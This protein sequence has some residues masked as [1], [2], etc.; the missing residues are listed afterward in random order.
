MIGIIAAMQEELQEVLALMEN[1]HEDE[2]HGIHFYHGDLNGKKVV[3]MRSGI[4]KIN[5]TFATTLLLVKY[6][7]K[8]VINVGSAGGLRDD[9]RI[10]DVVVSTHVAQ[11]DLDVGRARG[12]LGDQPRFFFADPELVSKASQLKIEGAT[13]HQGLVVSGDQ[14]VVSAAAGSILNHFADAICVEMEACAVAQ[15]CFKMKMPFVIVR[16]ISDLPHETDNNLTFEEYLPLAA[17]NSARV[18]SALVAQI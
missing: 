11:H 17:R 3:L 5:A 9:L 4:A 1:W 18:T 7:V 13:I 2:I 16:S 8:H 12:E 6:G 14:F 15:V 10:L